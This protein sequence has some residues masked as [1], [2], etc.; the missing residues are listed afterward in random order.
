MSGVY[1]RFTGG[2]SS[3]TGATGS[4][5]QYLTAEYS[6]GMF[7]GVGGCSGATG[8]SK[9]AV[10]DF[11]LS[12]ATHLRIDGTGLNATLTAGFDHMIGLVS[13]GVVT[14]VTGITGN[15][16]DSGTT[17]Y[18][19]P[20]SSIPVEYSWA[21][22]NGTSGTSGNLYLQNEVG[23]FLTSTATTACTNA[24]A[25]L[26]TYYQ[27]VYA[28]T[29]PAGTPSRSYDFDTG[30]S[31]VNTWLSL[32]QNLV[33][34]QTAVV[35]TT[36]N[37]T[38]TLTPTVTVVP[39]PLG[40]MD[41]LSVYVNTANLAS[42]STV[43]VAQTNF[44]TACASTVNGKDAIYTFTVNATQQMQV[45][46]GVGTGTALTAGNPA[47]NSYVGVFAGSISLTNKVAGGCDDQTT[48]V[49]ASGGSA[50]ANAYE[51]EE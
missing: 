14:P 6:A 27:A 47:L 11:S 23:P 46:T 10:F 33:D 5:G 16:T 38:G 30:G 48:V 26:A 18:T 15:F 28:L 50:N 25:P 1:R 17:P 29:I 44:G 12:T 7:N 40:A 8:T 45:T 43:K 34:T 22:F 20:F 21:Q 2:D 9:D 36:T 13:R 19:I 31:A 32:H 49:S 4:T 3:G 35:A 39:Q 41:E 51:T 37:A 24:A 42:T